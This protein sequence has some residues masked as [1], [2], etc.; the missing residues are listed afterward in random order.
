MTFHKLGSY[1]YSSLSFEGAWNIHTQYVKLGF[2][3]SAKQESSPVSPRRSSL[4]SLPE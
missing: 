2:N 3:S 1:V 4:K